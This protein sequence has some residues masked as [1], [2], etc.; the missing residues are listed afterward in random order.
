MLLRMIAICILLFSVLFM[1]FWV[2]AILAIAGMVYFRYFTEA[3]FLL[4]LSDLLYG[5]AEE[6]FWGITFIS[7]ILGIVVMLLIEFVKR[8]TRFYNN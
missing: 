7:F 3:V 1:P 5:I 2:T 8:K 6:K 4:L